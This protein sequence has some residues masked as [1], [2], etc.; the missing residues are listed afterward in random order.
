MIGAL[1]AFVIATVL[2]P[3]TAIDAMNSGHFSVA[4]D[5]LLSDAESGDAGAQNLL[6]NLYYLG[7]GGSRDYGK[8]HHWYLKSAAQAHAPAQ[9]N[10][11]RLFRDGLGVKQDIV[12]A[13][14]WLQQARMNKSEVA[15][16]EARWMIESVAMSANQ[17]QLAR[18]RYR[19]LEDLLAGEPDQ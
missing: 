19:V 3:K 15:E 18:E 6:G 13:F 14:A 5:H 9:V 17:I 1:I 7:L 16:N 4:R 12:K 10:I 8:A 2:K 11:A